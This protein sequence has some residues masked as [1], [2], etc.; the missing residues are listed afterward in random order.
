MTDRD[1]AQHLITLTETYAAHNYHPLPIVLR[2]GHGAWVT[3]VDGRR[4]LDCLAGYSALNFGHGHPDL[5]AAA[6]AQLDRLT[7]TSRAFYSEEMALFARDLA[8]LTGKEMV[9]PMN[10]GAE[11]VETAIKVARRWGYEVKGVPAHQASMVVMDG[12]FH[13][14]TTTIVSFST[15]EVARVGYSPYTP[16]F[17]LAKYG[18]LAA[19]DERI[20]DTTVA[21]LLEPIQGEGG[22]VIPPD[23]FLREVREMCSARGVLMIADE[24]QSGLARTGRTFACDHE[25]VVPDMYILGKA[26]GG[27]IL[28]VSAVAADRDVLGV[29]TPGSHGS[30]FGGN[31]F[32]AA[33]GR[34]V[35]ALLET[36]DFQDRAARLGRRLEEGLRPL[37]GAGLVE[38][39]VRGLWAGL[40][41]DPGI[42][43]GREMSVAMME[44]GLLAKD[45]HGSTIRLAPPIVASKKDIDL[46]VSTITE[47]LRERRAG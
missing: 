32:A 38:L 19:I 21:V 27:G 18:S 15:D 41:I 45:T 24:I 12:N 14:R 16:G 1:D 46:I 44:R 28:P 26:L 39:R 9:L 37:V 42:M 2:E 11:A 40:D 31:P 43:T 4:F 22:V 10:S 35:V 23:G 30:T 33:V 6:H 34:A 20:D 29:I 47:I 3:D 8:R 17:R 7:L 25:D 13:G 36:G 5:V